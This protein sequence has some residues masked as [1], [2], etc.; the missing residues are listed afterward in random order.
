MYRISKMGSQYCNIETPESSSYT[1]L[2]L[3]RR[4][5]RCGLWVTLSVF[6][7][8]EAARYCAMWLWFRAARLTTLSHV[9]LL[10]SVCVWSECIQLFPTLAN[11]HDTTK[12]FPGCRTDDHVQC[13]G[14]VASDQ[15]STHMWQKTPHTVQKQ[16]ILNNIIANMSNSTHHEKSSTPKSHGVSPTKRSKR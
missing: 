10:S 6:V 1:Y 16:H 5:I 9:H 13:V 4:D 2:V 8:D 14:R 7:G 15:K 12:C 11:S 3:F